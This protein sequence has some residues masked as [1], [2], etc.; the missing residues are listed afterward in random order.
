MKK[1]LQDWKAVANNSLAPKERKMFLYGGHDSTI[2]NILR[3]LQV[4][5]PQFPGFGI[6]ILFEFSKDVITNTYG[7]EVCKI[8]RK[9]LFNYFCY[10]LQIFLRNST[11]SEPRQLTIPGCSSFCPLNKL[12]ELTEKVVPENWELECQTDDVNFEINTQRGP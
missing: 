2:V 4:W 11:T 8:N 1:L 10:I 5:D 12:I 6:M 9:F 3:T 7:L